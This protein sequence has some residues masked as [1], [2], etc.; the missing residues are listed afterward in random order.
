MPSAL[1]GVEADMRRAQEARAAR[2][3]RLWVWARPVDVV[4]AAGSPAPAAARAALGGAVGGALSEALEALGLKAWG[5]N[6]CPAS[7]EEAEVLVVAPRA[8]LRCALGLVGPQCA[9][10]LSA[11][12]ARCPDL[13]LGEVDW[14]SLK[15]AGA[16]TQD[17]A[18]ALGRLTRAA[19]AAD[20]RRLLAAALS[21]FIIL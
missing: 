9:L 19:A 13:R 14:S 8:A 7:A 4:D 5:G 10:T 3:R 17:E 21:P 18:A 1:R 11:S 16:H 2:E 12:L 6:A 20:L 15:L